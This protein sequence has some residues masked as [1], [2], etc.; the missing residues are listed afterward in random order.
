L[1]KDFADATRAYTAWLGQFLALDAAG[2]EEKRR[3]M[4]HPR[5]SAFPFLR[6]TFYRWRHHLGAAGKGVRE[7]PVLLAVGDVHLEN[8]GTWRDAEGRLV[9]GL[10]DLDEA[11]PLPFA[12][13][14]VRL[15]TSLTLVRADAGAAAPMPD[16]EAAAEAIL[17]GYHAGIEAGGAPIVLEADAA[18]API[19]DAAMRGFDPDTAWRKLRSDGE[20]G[21]APDLAL[22]HLLL[23][24]L[25]AGTVPTEFRRAQKGLGSLGRARWRVLGTWNGGPVAREAKATA[26]SAV[27]M[28]ERPASR[29]AMHRRLAAEARRAP[30]PGFLLTERWSIRRLSPE[31]RKLELED[32][33]PGCGG[34]ASAG[35]LAL[36]RAMGAELANLHG[37]TAT[38]P[39]AILDWLAAR[40]RRWLHRA[41]AL[42]AERVLED[43]AAFLR[44][45][46]VVAEMP[47]GRA[48]A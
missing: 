2:L 6:G 16:P 19:R 1:A 12:S 23:T 39:A 45:P 32:L 5:H 28:P 33:A 40:K 18:H 17:D 8:F 41:A 31:A 37:G 22:A 35:Q 4:A 27:L 9:W 26:P 34:D 21:H 38:D 42:A 15:A 30:D 7:A 10:N 46:A 36:L 25:P 11:A 48:A 43:H 3:R 24:A 47:R 14:L 20:A 29:I 13:D 44:D